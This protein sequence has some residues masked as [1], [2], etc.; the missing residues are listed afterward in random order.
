[1]ELESAVE[2]LY[3]DESLSA[4]VDDATAQPLLKWAEAQLPAI[5]E[6]F[7]DEGFEDAF[8][9]F[10]KLIKSVGRLIG[11]RKGADDFDRQDRIEKIQR[12]AGKLNIP[13][14]T[15][16]ITADIA[17]QSG[18]VILAQVLGAPPLEAFSVPIATPISEEEYFAK[19]PPVT[20]VPEDAVP[21]LDTTAQAVVPPPAPRFPMTSGIPAQD[22]TATQETASPETDA[23]QDAQ[24]ES[25]ESK[26]PVAPP[27]F[28][29]TSGIPAQDNTATQETSSPETDTVQDAQPESTE[30]TAAPETPPAGGIQ[31]LFQRMMDALKPTPPEDDNSPK[32]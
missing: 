17:K 21:P 9:T 4:D 6:K 10:K 29:M 24:P 30:E 15:D 2:R 31:S 12:F 23:A 14:D 20:G 13:V 7:G 5:I 22:N 11:E 16:S 1:M 32:E 25:A 3:T 18:P 19:N 8:I 28:P 27:R 26:T